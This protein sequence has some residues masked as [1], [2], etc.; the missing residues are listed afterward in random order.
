[1]MSRTKILKENIKSWRGELFSSSAD[2]DVWFR[3]LHIGPIGI[4][5][6]KLMQYRVSGTQGSATVRL[7][8]ERADFFK[9]ID[10]YLSKTENKSLVTDSDIKN[11]YRL[12]IRDLAMRSF[13]A[14]ISGNKPLAKGLCPSL[15]QFDVWIFAFY[16]K[17]GFSTLVLIIF[18]RFI[19]LINL[20]NHFS[21][22][23]LWVKK[24]SGK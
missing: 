9:V 12:E 16:G 20:E 15:I 23:L 4:L 17:R 13:N 24:V 22:I 3:L 19:C 2:L 10:Y 21:P 11:Y 14:L 7:K 18:I 1:M 6:A 5:P 8:T